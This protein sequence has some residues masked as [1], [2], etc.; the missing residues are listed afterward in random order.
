MVILRF[1][2]F[3]VLISSSTQWIS[4][5][6]STNSSKI[7]SCESSYKS[8]S[9]GTSPSSIFYS[10]TFLWQKRRKRAFAL[11]LSP[12]QWSVNSDINFLFDVFISRRSVLRLE[13]VSHNTANS[14]ALF[15]DLKLSWINCSESAFLT[16]VF[17]FNLPCFFFDN[18][19]SLQTVRF[20]KQVIR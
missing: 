7:V 12:S 4:F 14:V 5:S 8:V 11:S 13:F 3:T 1:L 9:E 20:C 16:F 19:R 17:F 2:S 6:I 15:L 18:K 10:N